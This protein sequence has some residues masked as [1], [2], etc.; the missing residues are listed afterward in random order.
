[1]IHRVLIRC[2]TAALFCIF[3]TFAFTAQAAIRGERL[4]VGDTAPTLDIE[5]WLQNGNGFF[6]PVKTFQEDNVY[7]VEFWA[8]WCGPCKIS[9]PMLAEL[10]NKYRGDKVQIIGVSNEPVETIERMMDQEHGQVDKTFRE[11]TSAYSLATDPDNSVSD[12][13]MLA[14]GQ[15]GIPTAFIVGKTGKIEWIGSPFEMEGPLSQVVDGTWDQAT[16]KKQFD[17][18]QQLEI[19]Q[20]TIASFEQ[21]GE[22]DK[23]IAFA[24]KKA[25]EADQPEIKARWTSFQHQLKLVYK[26]I[27]QET[28]DY[29]RQQF[30]FFKDSNDLR[31]L[32]MLGGELYGAIEMGGQVNGLNQEAIDALESVNP[33]D[34]STQFKAAYYNTIALLSESTGDFDKAIE[35]QI[36]AMKLLSD[37]EQ[38]R[39]MP[40]LKELREKAEKAKTAKEKAAGG[41]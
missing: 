32:L 27:D 5:H 19:D 41:K 14:A 17:A 16:F 6:K 35:Q 30:Q 15:D 39:M 29:Y 31:G 24:T 12:D 7:V 26:K 8:T 10:Q 11:I 40:F 34:A 37:R 2:T 25:K 18:I 9:M 38:R 4:T 23:A 1:M 22:I 3:A 33:N 28:V 20:A 36:A 13:Y 21:R